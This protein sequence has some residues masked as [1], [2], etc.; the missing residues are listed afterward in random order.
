M[1]G[2]HTSASNSCGL[3]F[4]AF[5]AGA[6]RSSP[7]AE[8]EKVTATLTANHRKVALH[9]GGFFMAESLGNSRVRSQWTKVRGDETRGACAPHW[10]KSRTALN[11]LVRL[12]K[13]GS[14]FIALRYGVVSVALAARRRSPPSHCH[15]GYAPAMLAENLVRCRGVPKFSPDRIALPSPDALSYSRLDI[16]RRGELPARRCSARRFAV[17][18]CAVFHCN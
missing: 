6:A 4:F 5:E 17:Q 7:L 10:R 14:R 2:F 16:R 1:D 18:P 8:T 12:W 13:A 3:S 9:P 15:W 11:E